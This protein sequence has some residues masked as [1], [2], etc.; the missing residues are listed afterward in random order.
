[1]SCIRQDTQALVSLQDKHW[2]CSCYSCPW[3]NWQVCPMVKQIGSCPQFEA[4]G[5]T[6]IVKCPIMESLS[7]IWQDTQVFVSLHDEDP[8]SSCHSCPCQRFWF[9]SKVMQSGSSL[10]PVSSLRNHIHWK[11][12]CDRIIIMHLIRDTRICSTAWQKPVEQLSLLSLSWIAFAAQGKAKWKLSP[13]WSPRNHIH[14]KQ[15][16]DRIIVMHLRICSGIYCT[17]WQKPVE[18]LSLLTLSK[19][20]VAVQGEAKW[21]LLVPSLKPKESHSLSCTSKVDRFRLGQEGAWFHG[22]EWCRIIISSN[23]ILC[24][25]DLLPVCVLWSQ[26]LHG[27]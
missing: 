17:A 24:W 9:H 26:T 23:G 12:F 22:A 8:L 21:Q 1:M 3:H 11:M 2:L 7:C 10:S 16:C 18:Q 20:L 4:Q 14:C 25:L 27:T 6:F 15:C 19:I 5:I 13:V